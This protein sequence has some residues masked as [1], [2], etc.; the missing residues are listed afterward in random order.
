MDELKYESALDTPCK[1]KCALDWL[2]LASFPGIPVRLV[3]QSKCTEA[4]LD[5]CLRSSHEALRCLMTSSRRPSWH[6]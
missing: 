5:A 2:V 6:L 1:P 3:G 4:E